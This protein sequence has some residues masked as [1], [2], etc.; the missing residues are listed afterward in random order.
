VDLNI[1]RYIS[2]SVADKEIDL[3]AVNADLVS[4]DQKIKAATKKH[5]DYLEQL[6]PPPLP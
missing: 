1:S 2:T 6:G 5:N 3:G 4:L